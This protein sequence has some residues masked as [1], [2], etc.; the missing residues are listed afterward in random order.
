[1]LATFFRHFYQGY[2]SQ[3]VTKWR[4]PRLLLVLGKRRKEVGDSL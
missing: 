3:G 2:G 1:M 4:Y